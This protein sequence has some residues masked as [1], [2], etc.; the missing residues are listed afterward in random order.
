LPPEIDTCSVS[1]RKEH[2]L[3]PLQNFEKGEI[4]FS[5][6]AARL[7]E[8]LRGQTPG[9]DN[10][11]DPAVHEL[12]A[13]LK[14]HAAQMDRLKAE[15][16]DRLG[17]GQASQAFGTGLSRNHYFS[18]K[19]LTARDLKD[20]QNYFLGKHRRHNRYLHGAGVVLGLEV[21]TMINRVQINPGY[22]LD[23]E[24]NEIIISEPIELDLPEM[25]EIYILLGHTERMTEPIPTAG[26]AHENHIQYNRIEEG[27]E[28][29]FEPQDPV[30]RHA[31][32]DA[33]LIPCGEPHPIPIAKL[34]SKRGSWIVDSNFEM[35]RIKLQVSGK[36]D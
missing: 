16:K 4:L 23:C 10:I 35:P 17:I 13:Q 27:F 33:G 3:M 26:D 25:K 18:G 12:I 19:L 21:A 28:F 14:K 24:G 8:R 32:S 6:M 22:A 15:L 36:K 7:I 31:R 9:W 20:E 34:Q 5:D 29:V 2:I 1:V 11:H 30:F